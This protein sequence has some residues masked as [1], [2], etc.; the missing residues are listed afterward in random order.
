[1]KKGLIITGSISLLVVLSGYIWM[2]T[3][4]RKYDKACVSNGGIVEKSGSTC[5]MIKCDKSKFSCSF[6]M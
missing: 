4:N 6:F 1:M 2:K 5:D 3:K